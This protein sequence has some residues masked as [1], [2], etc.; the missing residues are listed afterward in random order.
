MVDKMVP[1]LD[2]AGRAEKCNGSGEA[3]GQ[4]LP[5]IPFLNGPD[6]KACLPEAR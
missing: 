3:H 2:D 4:G 5:L 1:H 6:F